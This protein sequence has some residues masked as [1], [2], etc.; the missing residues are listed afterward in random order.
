MSASF[1]SPVMTGA[2]SSAAA[3]A[4]LGIAVPAQ[5][6][7]TA[8][9]IIAV[10]D[11]YNDHLATDKSASS[12]V[13]RQDRIA[14]DATMLVGEALDIVG[15]TMPEDIRCALNVIIAAAPI[16]DA[17]PKPGADL[18]KYMT[19]LKAI[20]SML[21]RGAAS[22]TGAVAGRP[23]Q[24]DTFR[25]KLAG[26][27]QELKTE[28]AAA[29]RHRANQLPPAEAF[30]SGKHE[31]GIAGLIA[32]G[33]SLLKLTPGTTELAQ[34][35][36]ARLGSIHTAIE[37][38]LSAPD[39]IPLSLDSLSD[40]ASFD[41]A[42]SDRD[43]LIGA[44]KSVK[45]H[46]ET[47][48]SILTQDINLNTLSRKAVFEAKTYSTAA[49]IGVIDRI[50]IDQDDALSVTS[51]DALERARAELAHRQEVMGWEDDVTTLTKHEIQAI[52]GGK[53]KYE[54]CPT[55][56]LEK[57]APKIAAAI[58][59]LVDTVISPP[60]G[61]DSDAPDFDD[62][63]GDDEHAP[64][65]PAG[66]LDSAT[67]M[68]LAPSG[69]PL[70]SPDAREEHIMTTFLDKLFT[71][72]DIDPGRKLDGL[73]RKTKIE[74]R[75][76][77][78]WS[79]IS[80]PV[81]LVH[82]G[83]I[84]TLTSE[85]VPQ[86]GL[87][88]TSGSRAPVFPALV[89]EE[90]GAQT[91]VNCHQSANYRHPTNLAQTRLLNERGEELFNAT[92]HG[93]LSAYDI[94]SNAL[95][96]MSD[97]ELVAVATFLFPD[98]ET[99]A[100]IIPQALAAPHDDDDDDATE[101]DALMPNLPPSDDA[102]DAIISRIRTDSEVRAVCADRV[103]KTAAAT[104]AREI[105]LAALACHPEKLR[106][107]EAG[108]PGVSISI[109]TI[110]LLTPDTMRGI[111]G[112]FRNQKGASTGGGDELA[113]VRDQY[114]AWEHLRQHG[115]EVEGPGGSKVRVNVEVNDFNFGV[116]DIEY[117]FSSSERDEVR[118]RNT[119]AM[120]TVIGELAIDPTAPIGGQVGE[121]LKA[122]PYDRTAET[123]AH[124]IADLWHSGASQSAG[125][126]P[127]KLVTRLAVLTHKIGVHPDFNCKS[128]KDRTGELDVEAKYLAWMIDIT[129]EVPE[130]DIERDDEQRGNFY[131]L[132]MEGGN[133]EL[134]KLNTGVPGFKLK[135]TPRVHKF[136]GYFEGGRELMT[137]ITLDRTKDDEW[138]MRGESIR[139]FQGLASFEG[140]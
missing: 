21:D 53:G 57:R 8:N 2:S 102:R 4:G 64:L 49:A 71:K 86:A 76:C 78:N 30:V 74:L 58:D 131:R 93:T 26:L 47:R 111:V 132:A 5:P 60:A 42:L 89:D 135:A 59:A 38:A 137:A 99:I 83:H 100:E 97:A 112:W 16:L 68:P 121:W 29:H 31:G 52:M 113:M 101:L 12:D 55:A 107:A 20:E 27:L 80:R 90:T 87:R 116:N 119:R 33:L 45:K 24:E 67:D 134:Q 96:A 14:N 70:S 118:E 48:I 122:H 34:D 82:G 79:N 120:Q 62:A 37:N 54:Y 138:D 115:I 126:E 117:L 35:L 129:G 125:I 114:Q 69:L 91:G 41:R 81:Q 19:D 46:I 124:Q 39:D 44:L 40:D 56:D 10:A 108:L 136:F 123:L 65:L 72:L 128:G 17:V 28:V 85:L 7:F 95:L 50:L 94:S 75:D 61:L 105:A 104:R 25:H 36:K 92:R 77:A 109:N 51:K 3:A 133:V 1:A 110:S 130:P 106:A 9:D 22:I 88:Y 73:Y 139:A 18:Q 127:Y 63:L 6:S 43:D 98:T 23:A 13:R 140:S 84:R 11:F 15:N 32:T 66:H 103:R